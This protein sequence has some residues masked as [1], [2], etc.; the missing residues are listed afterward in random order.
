MQECGF[1]LYSVPSYWSHYSSSIFRLQ[2]A[3]GF[4]LRGVSSVACSLSPTGY[5]SSACLSPSTCQVLLSSSGE[6]V[7]GKMEMK[8]SSHLNA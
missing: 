1:L 8:T 2:M 4:L 5:E 3:G 6:E 7:S